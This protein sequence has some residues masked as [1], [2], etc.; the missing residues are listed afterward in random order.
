MAATEE[1]LLCAARSCLHQ[2]GP[3]GSSALEWLQNLLLWLFLGGETS[4]PP[5]FAV[6]TLG[7]LG[8]WWHLCYAVDWGDGE[9]GGPAPGWQKFVVLLQRE[10]GKALVVGAERWP[11]SPKAAEACG[12]YDHAGDRVVRKAAR[13]D[14]ELCWGTWHSS[15]VLG[16]PFVVLRLHSTWGCIMSHDG[17]SGVRCLLFFT[18]HQGEGSCGHGP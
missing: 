11:K 7:G 8:W 10:E 18:S 12:Q 9:C 4:C 13:G 17:V 3:S 14:M 15:V 16:D 6:Q 1:Q 2:S 5:C